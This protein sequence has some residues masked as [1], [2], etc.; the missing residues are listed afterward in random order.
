[1]AANPEYWHDRFE[2]EGKRKEGEWFALT[3]ADPYA[4]IEDPVIARAIER[5]I[6][7]LAGQD[8]AV[9]PYRHESESCRGG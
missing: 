3:D 6:S 5:W 4:S 2:K 7:Q 1:V 9:L 8:R